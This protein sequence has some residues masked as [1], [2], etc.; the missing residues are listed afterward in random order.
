MSAPAL[1]IAN[2]ELTELESA[3]ESLGAPRF[4]A[5][6]LFQWLYRRGVGD[7]GEMTDLS[8]ELRALMAVRFRVETPEVVGK[9][10]SIDA[11]TKFL[12]RLADGHQ[13]ESVFIP[14][15]PAMTFCVSTQV[16]CAMACAFCLTGKMGIVRNLTAGKSSVRSACSRARSACSTR[17]STSC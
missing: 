6:Q 3:V 11:T 12:L 14:D 4:H 17:R 9:E 8:R 15:T 2:L 1:D 10:T 13:I 5:R 7:F 16:G